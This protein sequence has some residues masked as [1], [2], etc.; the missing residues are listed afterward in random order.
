VIVKV[1]PSLEMTV[2]PVVWY[3]PPVFFCSV[4]NVLAVHEHAPYLRSGRGG[5]GS[6]AP[7]LHVAECKRQLQ[8]ALIRLMD[9]IEQH[10]C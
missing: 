10:G 4:V 8:E 6:I 1:L 7:E 9:H 5:E 2:R 3:F